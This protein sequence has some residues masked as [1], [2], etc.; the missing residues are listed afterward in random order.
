[1]AKK[2]QRRFRRK[3]RFILS[4]YFFENVSLNGTAQIRHHLR[5]ETT[6]RR[7]DVH[8]HDDRRRA[9][10]RHRCGKIRCAELK[11]IVEPYHV[12]HRVDC[13]PTLANLAEDAVGIGIDSVESGAIERGTETFRALMRAQ[14]METLIR[15][16]SQHQSGKQTSRFLL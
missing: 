13:D 11:A 14:E 15:V 1:V 16:L 12:F 6:F 7:R 9:T 3:N 4:L 2:T 10:D 8:R 5:T